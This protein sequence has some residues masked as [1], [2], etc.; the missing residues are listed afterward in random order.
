MIDDRRELR[1]ALLKRFRAPPRRLFPAPLPLR[2]LPL[3]PLE[4]GLALARLDL[5]RDDG[6][7]RLERPGDA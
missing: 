7:G 5:P 2:F 4:L 1:P 3:P 6:G